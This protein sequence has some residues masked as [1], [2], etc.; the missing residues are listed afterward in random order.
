MRSS[1][2]CWSIWDYRYSLWENDNSIFRFVLLFLSSVFCSLPLLQ[3]IHSKRKGFLLPFYFPIL[4][5]NIKSTA[6]RSWLC[7]QHVIWF[8]WNLECHSSANIPLINS[9]SALRCQNR[10]LK[11]FETRGRSFSL[12]DS[13]NANW[14]SRESLGASFCFLKKATKW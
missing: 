13:F 1:C 12:W 10:I 3:T 2:C 7:Q 6:D 4:L 9:M 11:G 14:F 8:W 5:A